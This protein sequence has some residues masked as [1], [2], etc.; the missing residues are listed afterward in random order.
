MTL[1]A[2]V[3]EVSALQTPITT[4]KQIMTVPI[5]Y[6]VPK[7]IPYDYNPLRDMQGSDF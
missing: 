6:V 1:A 4:P 7:T 2:S 5:D 3:P